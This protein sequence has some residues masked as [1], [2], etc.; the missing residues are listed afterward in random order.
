[1]LIYFPW[2]TKYPPSSYAPFLPKSPALSSH[3]YCLL[4][5]PLLTASPPPLSNHLQGHMAT[6]PPSLTIYYITLMPRQIL[7]ILSI[8][9]FTKGAFVSSPTH[10][11]P[12][13]PSCCTL[14]LAPPQKQSRCCQSYHSLSED[15]KRWLVCQLVPYI[16]IRIYMYVYAYWN[17]T[18]WNYR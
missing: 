15:G 14:A 2:I 16:Y 7:P 1:M 12:V 11:P 5:S 6:P 3:Q 18:D 10:L 4:S 13:L 9:K 8:F 17:M